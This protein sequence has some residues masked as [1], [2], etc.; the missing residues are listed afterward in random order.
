MSLTGWLVLLVWVCLVLPDGTVTL[1]DEYDV[2]HVADLRL[3]V[4][5]RVI[6]ELELKGIPAVN[7]QVFPPS[8]EPPAYQKQLGEAVVVKPLRAGFA[9]FRQDTSDADGEYY[10]VVAPPLGVLGKR[11]FAPASVRG[12][13]C[14]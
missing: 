10:W 1:P 12:D 14:S 2:R 3:Q 13:Q 8:P 9:A 5:K 6:R 11:T 7:L 4:Q